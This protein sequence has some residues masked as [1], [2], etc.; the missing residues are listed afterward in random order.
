MLGAH[1]VP[2]CRANP[3]TDLSA[4]IHDGTRQLRSAEIGGKNIRCHS[5]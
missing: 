5:N 3:G 2:F 1:T 4:G